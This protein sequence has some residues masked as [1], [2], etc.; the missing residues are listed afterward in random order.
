MK[1][2][3][4][5]RANLN[6]FQDQLNGAFGA[7]GQGDASWAPTSLRPVTMIVVYAKRRCKPDVAVPG[8][9][10]CCGKEIFQVLLLLLMGLFFC[11]LQGEA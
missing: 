6:R 9:Q 4:W 8:G 1:G 10:P 7:T 2:R 5:F 3:D 11:W